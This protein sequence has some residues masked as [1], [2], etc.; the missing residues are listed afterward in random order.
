[1]TEDQKPSVGRDVHYQDTTD[2]QCFAA[3]IT[4]VYAGTENVSLVIFP[5]MAHVFNVDG[6]SKGNPRD[7]NTWHWPERV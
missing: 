7:E 5:S 4:R 6:I 2:G 1:M 3:K